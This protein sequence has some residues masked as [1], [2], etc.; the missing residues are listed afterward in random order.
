MLRVW[1]ELH[2]D[3]QR[4]VHRVEL[5]CKSSNRLKGAEVKLQN[6]DVSFWVFLND[7]LPHYRCSLCVPCCDND[8]G[9]SHRKDSR[10]LQTNATRSSCKTTEFTDFRKFA[11]IDVYEQFAVTSYC[12]SDTTWNLLTRIQD[13]CLV[14]TEFYDRLVMDA[15]EDYD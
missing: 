3:V 11:R 4:K 13:W 12:E 8:M 9:S 5:I 2:Q 10:G 6:I 1:R 15:L 14:K 7:F